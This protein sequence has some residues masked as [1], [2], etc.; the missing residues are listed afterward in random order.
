MK[1]DLFLKEDNYIDFSNSLIQKKATEI[2]NGMDGEREKAEAAYRYVRDQIPHSFDV[3]ASVI[4]AKA[5]DVLYYET[6]I[7]HAKANLLAALLR[8]QGIPAGFCFQHITLVEDDS[9]G[10][11]LHGYNAVFIEGKWIQLDARGNK[12]GVSAEFSMDEPILAFPNRIEYEE[13]FFSGI[14]ADP[15]SATMKMLERATTIQ[16]VMEW[17]PE[18]PVNKPDIVL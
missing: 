2:F 17:L 4:T 8:S 15:D 7:C 14:Y 5:S 6:G 10:Y 16:E 1:Y 9:Y 13:Y 3:N 11:C 12:A 18:Y